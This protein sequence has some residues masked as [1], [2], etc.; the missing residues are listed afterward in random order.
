MRDYDVGGNGTAEIADSLDPSEVVVVMLRL[1]VLRIAIILY[2]SLSIAAQ[3]AYASVASARGLEDVRLVASLPGSFSK[4][5]I[6][7]REYWYA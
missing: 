3:T 7:G 5:P 4:K 1:V 6:K 2:A